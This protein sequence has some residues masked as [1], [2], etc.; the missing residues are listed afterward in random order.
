MRRLAVAAGLVAAAAVGA[1]G[2]T[3]AECLA[4]GFTDALSCRSCERL[5]EVVDEELAAE[6]RMCCV[7]EAA[8]GGA[9]R[10]ARARLSVC[11]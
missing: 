3:D 9:S 8:G 10:Y 2:A 11:K 7:E 5:A 4:M 1:R 6:C